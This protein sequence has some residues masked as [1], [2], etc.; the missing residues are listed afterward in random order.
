L[1]LGVQQTLLDQFVQVKFRRVPWDGDAFGGP[2]SADRF[3]LGGHEQVQL[4][5]DRV[6]QGRQTG[7]SISKILRSHPTPSSK[8]H[9]P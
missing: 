5:A 7:H 1:G 9:Q 2:V 6:G 3:G 8:G 4:T